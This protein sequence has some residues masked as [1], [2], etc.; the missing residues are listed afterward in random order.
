MP[1]SIPTRPER[2]RIGSGRELMISSTAL[3]PFM[4]GSSRSM[5]TRSGWT[6]GSAAMASAAVVHTALTL[7]S[8]SR[9]RSRIRAAAYTGESSHT[10][11]R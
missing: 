2:T 10:R 4:S 1:L 6:R 8:P 5:V 3:S 9:S 11:T 7:I